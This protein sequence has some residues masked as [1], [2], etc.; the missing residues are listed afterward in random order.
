MPLI[1]FPVARSGGP[2]FSNDFGA[3]RSGGRTHT[4]TDIFAALDTPAL[5]VDS[6]R[7]SY[8][9]A[10]L[11]GHMAFLTGND[12]QRYQYGHL[13]S[14]EPPEGVARQVRAGETIGYV[15]HSGNA[16][17]ELP[18]VHFEVRLVGAKVAL[19]PFELL[20]AVAPPGAYVR[21]PGQPDPGA[22]PASPAEALGRATGHSGAGKAFAAG[23][24]ALGVWFG[25]KRWGHG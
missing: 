21:L 12:G 20:R 5:A 24:L 2:T 25:V 14:Y 8:G 10:S 7:V 16:P 17:A 23:L 9:E 22:P 15:G 13:S 3:P 18:H 1:V 19:N 4:G 11:G 6:G